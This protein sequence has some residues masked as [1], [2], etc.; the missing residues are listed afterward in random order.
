MSF[1]VSEVK[2]VTAAQV[3]L[4]LG[5]AVILAGSV[6]GLAALGKDVVTIL[7]GIAAVAITVAGA[8]GWAKANQLTRDLNQVN[9]NVDQVREISNGRL[10]AVLEDNKA[11]HEKLQQ[12][13]TQLPP[14]KE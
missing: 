10:T 9:Q 1:V 13:L 4:I 11:L 5:L 2:Q 14:P 6:V 7:T 12:A 3:C 8:F